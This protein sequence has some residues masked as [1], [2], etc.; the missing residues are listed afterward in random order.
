MHPFWFLVFSRFFSTHIKILFAVFIIIYL[1]IGVLGVQAIPMGAFWIA[2]TTLL[3][4]F[5]KEIIERTATLLP[6]TL[7]VVP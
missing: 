2:S 5:R 1:G 3:K 4:L 7:Q 6:K